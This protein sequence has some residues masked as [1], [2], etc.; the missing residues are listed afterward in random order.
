MT[1]DELFHSVNTIVKYSPVG[2]IS[3]VRRN[4]PVFYRECCSLICYVTLLSTV[5]SLAVCSC[6]QD[7]SRFLCFQ[8][9]CGED[10][11]NILSDW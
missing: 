5:S 2:I 10:L 4:L 9:V 7:E 6:E 1:F 11:D 8:R 3:P